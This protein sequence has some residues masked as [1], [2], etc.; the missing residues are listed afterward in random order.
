MNLNLFDLFTLRTLGATEL[1]LPY[2]GAPGGIDC[3]RIHMIS[4]QVAP[5][6]RG[7]WGGVREG[8]VRSCGE[9]LLALATL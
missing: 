9:A 4:L 1:R 8:V 5:L 6:A 2:S 7:S 3:S